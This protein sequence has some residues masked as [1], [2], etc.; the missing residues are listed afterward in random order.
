M[1]VT[2]K[3]KPKSSKSNS[4]PKMVKETTQDPENNFDKGLKAIRLSNILIVIRGLIALLL[5]MDFTCNMDLFLLTCKVSKPTHKLRLELCMMT[6]LY[7][8]AVLYKK[9]YSL[10]W[11]SYSLSF[12]LFLKT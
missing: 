12:H 11:N 9:S 4:I 8:A 1:E 7:R 6:V 5:E 3:P 2:G 10:F